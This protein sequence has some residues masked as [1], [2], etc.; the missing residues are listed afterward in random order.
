MKII[1]GN[2]RIPCKGHKKAL[3][4][5]IPRFR[6]NSVLFSGGSMNRCTRCIIP[7][8]LVFVLPLT[9]AH[10][11]QLCHLIP[12]TTG[13]I[14]VMLK[15]ADLDGDGDID[16]AVCMENKLLIYE[17]DGTQT[18]SI[19]SIATGEAYHGVYTG[20]LDGDTDIDLITIDENIFSQYWYR[21]MGAMTFQQENLADI[22][23]SDLELIDFDDDS[24]MD[25]VGADSGGV[26][27]LENDGD[28]VIT[29]SRLISQNMVRG[30]LDVA[31]M[32][33]DGDLDILHTGYYYGFYLYENVGNNEF[34]AHQLGY[35]PYSLKTGII[36]ADMNNDDLMD[37]VAGTVPGWV[38]NVNQD[39]NGNFTMNYVES[40]FYYMRD[41]DVAD[42]NG[43]GFLDILAGASGITTYYSL[44]VWYNLNDGNYLRENIGPSEDHMPDIEPVD[45]DGDGDQDILFTYLACDSSNAGW[46]ENLGHHFYQLYADSTRIVYYFTQYGG[47]LD[48]EL[49]IVNLSAVSTELDIW[50]NLI[51]P[52]GD[53]YEEVILYEDLMVD[54]ADTTVAELVY[55]V[56]ASMEV[57][58]CSLD[59]KLG[60]Y[61]EQVEAS[62]L[63]GFLVG[64]NPP[65]TFSLIRPGGNRWVGYLP[66][67][68][69]WEESID[70]DP[71]P[72]TRY[73][74]WVGNEP[75]LS[76]AEMYMGNIAACQCSI[77]RYPRNNAYYW[78]VYAT[79]ANTLGTWANDTVC[80]T[81]DVPGP[82]SE[83]DLLF[84]EDNSEVSAIYNLPLSLTWT[85]AC[86]ADMF[87]SV[88]YT[89]EICED[90]LFETD[91]MTFTTQDT[92]WSLDTLALDTWFWRV[93]AT[94]LYE[95]STVSDTWRFLLTMGI[96]DRTDV[97]TPQT[98]SISKTCP[99]PFNPTLAVEIAIP[100]TGYL[101]LEVYNVLGKRVAILNDN[102]VTA[103]YHEF[104]WNASDCASGVYFVKATLQEREAVVSKVHLLK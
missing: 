76:D 96:A 12:D 75:D 79:D 15:S 28:G 103:G 11:E 55:Q 57:G 45:L 58:F 63:F 77:P 83:F 3:L 41:I 78:T 36:A 51:E 50:M 69:Q 66:G 29:I 9:T 49:R 5:N 73:E 71:H 60:H 56:P 46:Y 39:E 25:I 30:Y 17:N 93:T 40:R 89:I 81:T 52:D 48:A 104:I 7:L 88:T 20:D 47:E 70:L 32:D 61:P 33:G 6:T 16:I 22:F 8:L 67:D 23:L 65:S 100:E 59:I 99:N 74:V 90:E 10:A 101:Q 94:D 95:F 86:D 80:F 24:D 2:K 92:S 84:P 91:I 68:F 34:M 72:V 35:D 42:Y 27:L 53:V 21:N 62:A 54:Y 31:D 18:F 43:D 44:A 19:T 37:M 98:F 1:F 97:E 85:T 82:P 102:P 26:V 64:P 87:D 14:A 13:G 4:C 38:Y